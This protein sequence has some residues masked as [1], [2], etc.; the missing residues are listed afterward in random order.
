MADETP[1]EKSKTDPFSRNFDPAF[2]VSDVLLTEERF[3][4]ERFLAEYSSRGDIGKTCKALEIPRNR[5]VKWL[6]NDPDFS[7]RYSE[8]HQ[9]HIDEIEQTM[10]QIVGDASQPAGARV[11]AGKLILEAHRREV[12]KP[13]SGNSKPNVNVTIVMGK[14]EPSVPT[15]DT[16]ATHVE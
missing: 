4:Q 3:L 9:A 15:I 8:I 12:Y 5:V 1:T 11:A 13:D 16:Q 14:Q 6:A 2:S 7:Q 10:F